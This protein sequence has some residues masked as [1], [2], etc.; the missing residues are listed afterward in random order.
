MRCVNSLT[1]SQIGKP[2][3]HDEQRWFFDACNVRANFD[4]RYA[5]PF[6]VPNGANKSVSARMKFKREGLKSGVPD[7]FVPVAIGKYHGAVIEMKAGKNKLSETQVWWISE[8]S[9][10]G[11]A[12]TVQYS[13]AGAFDWLERYFAG[14]IK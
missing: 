14:E 11:Y 9:A 3:E 7:I 6:A 12:T 8:L 1:K 2:S 13:G 5:L 4:R 10:G